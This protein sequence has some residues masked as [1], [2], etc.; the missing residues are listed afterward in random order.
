[1]SF[2]VHIYPTNF[3]LRIYFRTDYSFGEEENVKREKEKQ[4]FAEI[5]L[6]LDYRPSVQSVCRIIASKPLYTYS[7]RFF[8][9]RLISFF[10]ARNMCAWG[11]TVYSCSLPGVCFR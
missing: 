7:F 2:D 3:T 1:M 6:L 5:L 10:K 4:S 9:S 11:S 8:L